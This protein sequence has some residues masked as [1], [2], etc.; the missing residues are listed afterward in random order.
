MSEAAIVAILKATAAVTAIVSS[1]IYAVDLPQNPTLPAI[2]YSRIS[3][4]RVS[5]MTG[6]SGLA[7]PRYQIDVFAYDYTTA[8]NLVRQVQLALEGKRGTYGG[9]N[10]QGILFDGDHDMNDDEEE[11]LVSDQHRVMMEF[12]VWHNE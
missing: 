10:V 2:V 3:G 5:S 4:M 7:R 11:N 8:K 9:V 12:T 1:R 6:A